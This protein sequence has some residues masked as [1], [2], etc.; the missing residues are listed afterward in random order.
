MPVPSG[1]EARRYAMFD[2]FCK[3]VAR[4]A[5]RNLK[6]K[7]QTLK[8]TNLTIINEPVEYFLELLGQE[9]RY[10]SDQFVISMD[11]FPCVVYSETLYQALLALPES[12]RKVILLEF[13]EDWSTDRIA[14][15]LEVSVRTVYNLK[16]RA[17]KAI[18]QYYENT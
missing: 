12:Q 1:K 2:S 14:K 15:N 4:N 16:Q 13:W 11:G 6:R 7:S 17:F 9:D 5:A 10:P 18:R 3:T 8:N